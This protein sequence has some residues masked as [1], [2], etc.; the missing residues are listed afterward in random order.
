MVLCQDGKALC[1]SL[2]MSE[3]NIN[4][5]LIK[6]GLTTRFIGQ[7]V[8]YYPSVGSTND[9]ARQQALL[10]APEG[11]V[12]VADIQ[13]TGR[14]RLKRV[15][16]SPPGN[17]A[18]TVVLYPARKNL[19]FLTMLASLAV[20]Y[21]IEKTTGLQCQLKWPN[22]VLIRNKKVCGI[23]LESQ[24]ATDSVEYA[25]VGIGINVNMR[26]ADYPEI[27]SIATSLA[28]ETGKQVARTTLL[29][30]LFL[31]M[32]KL[33]LRLQAGEAI[34]PEWREH[35]VTLGKQI[36]VR[37]GDDVFA[38][39]AESVADDGCLLLRCVDGRLMKFNTGDVTMR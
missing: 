8:L 4:E 30:N 3:E 28:D 7:N 23:L 16:V 2:F 21:S 25:I 20:L 31:E 38:G 18:V 39:V 27:A 14:G 1:Y 13:T 22:D 26:L 15:W 35:L 10:K 33:Y 29:Q 19:H 6:K 5:N 17:I 11:T 9:I 32:E 12:V 24:A 34:L 37:A 36:H